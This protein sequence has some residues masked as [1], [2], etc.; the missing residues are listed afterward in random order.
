[1]SG[2]VNSRP[3]Q[4]RRPNSIETAMRCFILVVMTPFPVGPARLGGCWSRP[5]AS[6][7]PAYLPMR[8]VDPLDTSENRERPLRTAGDEI[9]LDQRGTGEPGDADARS[10]GQSIVRKIGAVDAVHR[11]IVALEMRQVSTH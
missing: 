3:A 5:G 10:R 9:D 8:P 6:C 1:M 11:R 2:R 4:P 7:N